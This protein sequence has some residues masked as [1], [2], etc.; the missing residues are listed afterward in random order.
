[1]ANS[2]SPLSE[3]TK[4]IIVGILLVS[5]IALLIFYLQFF[6]LLFAGILV[7][8]FL[9]YLSSYFVKYLKFRYGWALFSVVSLIGL[10]IGIM[11]YFVGSSIVDQVDEMVKALPE[12]LKSLSNTISQNPMGQKLLKQIPDDPMSFII[13]KADALSQIWGS[14]FSTLDAMTNFLIVIVIGLFLAA[15]P[16]VYVNGFLRL[17]PVHFR[18]RL[19]DV[20]DKVHDTLSLWLIAKLCS[21]TVISLTAGIGLQIIGVPLPYALAFILAI[22]SF[23]PNLGTILAVIPAILIAFLGGINQVLY[24]ILLYIG[25][26]MLE[27]YVVTPFF[28]KRMVSLPPALTLTWMVLFG[29]MAG[30][31]GLI[32]ATPILAALIVLVTE[33]YVKDYLEKRTPLNVKK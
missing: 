7:S 14:F 26:E 6:L 10:F 2:T 30:L 15:T 28:E 8:V 4:S 17:F 11:M 12:I 1:M 20:M 21:M 29:L 19:E 9:N 33:L 23:I 25:V 3:T 16:S 5:F 27:S 22:L 13:S 31:T 24:V 18:A 32:L